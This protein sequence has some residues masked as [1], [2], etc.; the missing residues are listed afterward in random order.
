MIERRGAHDHARERLEGGAGG[1][2]VKG[3]AGVHDFERHREI[4]ARIIP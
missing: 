3:D 2:I 4:G 1:E